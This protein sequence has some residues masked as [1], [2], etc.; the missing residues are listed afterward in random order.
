MAAISLPIIKNLESFRKQL[1]LLLERMNPG[2][3]A[4]YSSVA[5]T[6][7]TA[8]T[9]ETIATTTDTSLLVD[10]L[11]CGR[12]TGGAAGSAGD[13]AGYA[14]SA[15]A[16]NVAGTVTIVAQSIT[17]TGESQAAWT[18]AFAVSGTSLLLQVTGAAN[19]NVNWTA[20]G[21]ALEAA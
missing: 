17:F 5:T 8:T 7:A 15:L 3:T 20:S 14:I 13:A 16:K 1:L 6:N 18:V 11:V 9:I 12:R 2:D 10:A 4:F 21:R 19:N